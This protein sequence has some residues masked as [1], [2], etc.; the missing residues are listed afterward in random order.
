MNLECVSDITI[1]RACI[2]LGFHSAMLSD[3]VVYYFL[4]C[5]FQ[6]EVGILKCL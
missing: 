2:D 4:A 1:A 3:V 6:F 5:V